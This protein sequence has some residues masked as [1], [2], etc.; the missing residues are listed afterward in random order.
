MSRWFAIQTF[1]LLFFPLGSLS[2]YSLSLV[3]FCPFCNTSLISLSSASH[4]F[5]QSRFP[6]FL[7]VQLCC[8]VWSV[9]SPNHGCFALDFL[10][11]ALKNLCIH[12]NGE[13]L[14]PGASWWSDTWYISYI[15]QY[16]SKVN[17]PLF[18]RHLKLCVS[19][20]IN[21]VCIHPDHSLQSIRHGMYQSELNLTPLLRGP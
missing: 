3:I 17:S 11:C 1:W 14:V 18:K 20:E 5:T 16:V 10:R 2:E 7:R 19:S 9:T 12:G 8:G 4:S 21:S 6:S 15:L 13:A